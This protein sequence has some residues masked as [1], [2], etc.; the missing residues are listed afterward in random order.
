MANENL[1]FIGVAIIIAALVFGGIYYVSNSATNSTTYISSSTPDRG[2][3]VSSVQSTRVSPDL[4]ILTLSVESK[5]STAVLSQSDAAKKVNDVKAA[6]KLLGINENDIKTSYYSVS[7]VQTGHYKCVNGT[8]YSD[9]SYYYTVSEYKTSH[10]LSVRTTDLTKAGTLVDSA[11]N[12]GATNIDSILF[13]L[14]PETESKIK[15]ELLQ[16]ASAATLVKAGKIASGLNA[17]IGK[18]LNVYE[19]TSYYAPEYKSYSMVSSGS[20]ATTISSGELEVSATVTVTYELN[21]AKLI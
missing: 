8:N 21:P 19:S 14:K 12:A 18:A 11:V 2:V 7:P 9:C 13:T 10:I 16:N 3:V 20:S 5:S 17:G 4:L 15:N 1:M 6:L